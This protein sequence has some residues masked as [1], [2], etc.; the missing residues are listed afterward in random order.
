MVPGV[1]AVV[2]VAVATADLA[3]A[4][5]APIMAPTSGSDEANDSCGGGCAA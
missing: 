2:A 5:D 1:A 4:A 3:S